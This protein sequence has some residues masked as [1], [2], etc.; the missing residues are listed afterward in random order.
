[1]ADR[2]VFATSVGLF[3]ALFGPAM[4]AILI[5]Q[6]FATQP[7]LSRSLIAQL[8]LAA[9]CGCVLLIVLCGERQTL[10]SVGIRPLHWRSIAWGSGFAVFLIWIYSPLLALA[11]AFAQIPWFTEGLARLSAYPIWYLMLAAIIGG[12]AEEFLYRGYSIERLASMTG[13]YWVA[14]LISVLVFGLAHVPLWG[15][16]AALTTVISGAIATAF[17]VWRRDLLANIVAHIATDFAGIVL[18]LLLTE[19]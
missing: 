3:L 12:T 16:S 10:S 7:S 14:G 15:W 5:E 4:L 19:K 1:M 13:N 8:V 6:H 17:Y 9:I 11:M 18:P 2:K